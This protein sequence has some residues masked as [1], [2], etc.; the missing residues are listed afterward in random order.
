VIVGR[1]GDVIPDIIKVLPE[2]RSGKEKEFKMPKKCPVCNGKI[3][4]K[5][6]EAVY[7]CI[8]PNCF[9]ILKE[10]FYHFVSKGAFDI[11][12]LGPKIIDRLLEEGLVSDPADIF[13]LKEGDILN[14]ER[15]GE[16]SAKKL[17]N[18]INSKKEIPFSKFIYSL[19]IRQVGEETAKDLS[20]YF[21]SIE[22][23]KNAS[24]ND[25]EKIK[26]IGPV[27]AENIYNWF[28][29]KKNI[30]FLEKLEKAG[31]KIINEKK[32]GE[33][34]KGKTFVFT[35]ELNSMTREEAKEKVRDL[36]GE[37]SESI[38]RKTDYLVVG[39]NP[40]SK[41]EKAQKIGI[42]IINEKEFLD[43]IK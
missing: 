17:I 16:K 26:D 31:I 22:E 8:N 42:K 5:E 41:L 28:H 39:E 1:A 3:F 30:E 33:K 35:G 24:C 25:L 38:S 2:L 21:N 11:E 7:R 40:G 6:G 29:N 37:V 32:E 19:G 13:N 20:D 9:A 4:K 27:T 12:G 36:N 23:L 18:S 10:R 15:F 34:L 43:L 14:L